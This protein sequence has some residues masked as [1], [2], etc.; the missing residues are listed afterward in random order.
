M[1]YIFVGAPTSGLFARNSITVCAG[2]LQ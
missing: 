1:Y 2:R